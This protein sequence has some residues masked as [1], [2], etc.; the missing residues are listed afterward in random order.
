MVTLNKRIN[1]SV[2]KEA[3][4][5]LVALAKR[6]VVPQATKARHLLERAL[7]WEEDSVWDTL[8]QN[9]EKKGVHFVSHK[10]AWSL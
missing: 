10:K 2:S 9:R 6:D 8:A 1:I 4:Q 3:R 5:T 7:E